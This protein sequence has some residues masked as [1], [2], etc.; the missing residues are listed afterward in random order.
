MILSAELVGAFLLGAVSATATLLYMGR[1]YLKRKLGGFLDLTAMSGTPR[2]S[3]APTAG[4]LGVGGGGGMNTG[5]K[6]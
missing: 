2:Y 1:R 6:P 3:T 4:K 5:Q